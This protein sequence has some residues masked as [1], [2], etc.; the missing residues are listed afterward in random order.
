MERGEKVPRGWI[1]G[2]G[3]CSKRVK[4]QKMVVR[5]SLLGYGG[6]HTYTSRTGG[7]RDSMA[8]YLRLAKCCAIAKST[9]L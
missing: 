3:G 7:D 9:S 6:L 5:V 8:A 1:S 2:G 4:I